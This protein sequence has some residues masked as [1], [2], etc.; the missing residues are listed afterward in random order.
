MLRFLW[1][2]LFLAASGW[3]KIED[4]AQLKG[5]LAGVDDGML[6]VPRLGPSSHR[7]AP[8]ESPQKLIQFQK[9]QIEEKKVKQ[10]V[11]MHALSLFDHLN[12]TQ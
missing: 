10:D 11:I 5:R 4:K 6:G 9:Y 8:P 7:G 3:A 12:S 1:P 2:P